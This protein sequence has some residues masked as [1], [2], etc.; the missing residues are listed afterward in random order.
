MPGSGLDDL[1]ARAERALELLERWLEAALRQ[2][3]VPER[4]DDPLAWRWSDG[5]LEPI[6]HPDLYPLGGLVG[7]ER[8]VARLLRNLEAFAD[9]RAAL[10]ALLY[11]ERGTGKSS[12]VRGALGELGSR[13][14]RL[15]EVGRDDLLDLPSLYRAL[16]GRTGRFV[17]FCDDLSF[18]EGDASYKALKSALDGALE[19]RPGN[20]LIVA[21]SNRRHLIPEHMS[22]NLAATHGPEGELHPAEATEEKLSLSDRF[23]LLLPFLAFDQPTYLRIVDHHAKDVGLA[24]RLPT[25][26]IHARALRFALE[27]ASRSGRTARQACIA[28]LQ[29][30]GT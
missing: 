12:A 7:V 23:G 9:G 17:L 11:G 20:V 28:I 26:E 24:G 22:E 13:G 14:L 5:R 6:H 15:V 1:R 3:P 16:R 2:E 8:S 4:E 18:E 21:T 19:A 27:R 10:D 30:L 25:E 29:E